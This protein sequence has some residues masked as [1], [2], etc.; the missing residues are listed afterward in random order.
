MKRPTEQHGGARMERDRR[1]WHY[2]RSGVYIHNYS[3]VTCK[4][5]NYHIT[6]VPRFTDQYNY[7]IIAI[8]TSVRSVFIR[9]LHSEVPWKRRY[10]I[11]LEISKYN[12]LRWML[13]TR[14]G[15]YWPPFFWRYLP[16]ENN[17]HMLHK[18]RS[19]WGYWPYWGRT[20]SAQVQPRYNMKTNHSL[21]GNVEKFWFW[22]RRTM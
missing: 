14:W 3:K 6:K 8:Q 9:C 19:C 22:N 15:S 13:K 18:D 12:I 17:F 4:Y 5:N 11:T 16:N 1:A 21:T 20:M 2:G 10:N 7:T